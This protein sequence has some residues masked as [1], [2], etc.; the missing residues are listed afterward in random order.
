[1][2][3]KELCQAGEMGSGRDGVAAAV[4]RHVYCHVCQILLCGCGFLADMSCTNV[5][6][7]YTLDNTCT[8]S[9]M[10]VLCRGLTS[11]SCYWNERKPI[12]NA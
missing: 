10:N 4:R 6:L 12:V 7:S 11:T 1:M 5:M 2:D 8:R 3:G 9:S